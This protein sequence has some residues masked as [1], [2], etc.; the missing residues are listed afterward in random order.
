[1]KNLATLI[2]IVDGLAERSDEPALLY[3]TVDGTRAI[4]R[5]AL[6][7]DVQRL[8]AGLAGRLRRGDTVALFGPDRPE[9][10]VAALAAVCAGMT[11]L[12]LDVQASSENLAHM[13][14]DSGARLVFTTCDRLERLAGAGLPVALLDAPDG[15]P[16][17]MAALMTEPSALPDIRPEDPAALFY[18][19]G[20][21]GLPK[22]VPL[23]HANLA[24]Q[25]NAI[26][27]TGLLGPGDRVGLPLPLHHVYPFVMGVLTP[28]ALGLPLIIPQAL[29]GP[30]VVQALRDGEA[31]IMIGVPRLYAALY[32]A[33]EAQVAVRGR[34]AVLLFS[35]LLA[36]SVWVRRRLGLH[37]GRWLFGRLHAQL[38]PRLR[39]LACGGAALDPALAWRLEGLGWRLAI[40]YGLTETAPLLAMNLPPSP[41]LDAVGSPV[42]G[43]EIKID[44]PSDQVGE[45]LARGPNVFAGYRNLPEKTREAFT[46]DGW[47]RTGDLGRM[48]D[49]WL[50]LSGRA[51]ELIVTAGGENIQPEEV[52]RAFAAHPFIQEFAL[53][54]WEDRLVGLVLPEPGAICRAGLMDVQAAAR[55]A[56]EETNPRLASYQR[57]VEFAVTRDPLPRTR[58]GKLRRHV[59]PQVYA[60]AR[61]GW[62]EAAAPLPPERWAEPDRL[63]LEDP[64]PRQVWEELVRRYP[65]RHLTPDTGLRL[66]LGVDSL[67]WLDLALAMQRL[68]GAELTE[69]AIAGIETV[70]DLLRAAQVAPAAARALSWERP[71][72]VLPAR[73]LAWLRPHRGPIRAAHRLLIALNRLLMRGA[74]RLQVTGLEHLSAG[75]C[76][77]A[78]NHASVLDP[79]ALAAA[80]PSAT[81]TR[82]CWG[83]WAGIAFGNPVTRGLSRIGRVLPLTPEQGALGALALA[84]AAIRQG[85][86]LVWFPEGQRSVTGQ[87][88]PLRPGLGLL[89]ARFPLPVVPVHIAGAFEAMPL[90]RRW[91]RLLPIRLTFGPPLDPLPLIAAGGEAVPSRITEAV[92]A[93][94]AALAQAADP[95]T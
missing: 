77:F 63:L 40:G 14:A 90:G 33:I 61:S 58:L 95:T 50:T 65:D 11:V 13:L 87:L 72:E 67:A 28:V 79:F 71:D 51:K 81:L 21:T 54:E 34:A 4:N 43:V 69:T 46:A 70:R 82:T 80:L 3:V 29:T 84:A 38:A 49:G 45:V 56:V 42:P 53:L 66:D 24:F 18:T 93:R 44:A 89:M 9:W 88:L 30:R 48:E 83:G 8:A 25:L 92:A 86:S 52:E 35:R 12:P 39:L 23:T 47:F 59:L 26:A 1:M 10:V 55:Q 74:F 73:E 2:P 62:A 76:V 78:P 20:T 15:D 60:A 6:H 19:S 22:G 7:G 37:L 75:P 68:T 94:L 16:R 85:D 31:T 57:I 17:G 36:F 41:R 32:A 5:G 64:A 27:A 91:P